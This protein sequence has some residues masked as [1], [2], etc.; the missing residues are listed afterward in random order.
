MSKRVAGKVALITGGARGQGRAHAM[1]LA[2]EGA[3]VVVVDRCDDLDTVPY[4]LA[5]PSDLDETVALV[6]RSGG[7]AMPVRADVRDRDAM[8]AAVEVAVSEFGG[9]DIVVANAGISNPSP[10]W[11]ITEAMWDEMI[12]VNLTGTWITV[13]AALPTLRGQGRGGS[14]VL[15]SSVAGLTSFPN[16][17]HYTAAKHGV[18]GLMR[19]LA[20]DLAPYSIR[21][22]SVHP[23]NVAT[24]M[25]HNQAV[26]DL[27]TGGARG[28]TI[29]DVEPIMR[30]GNALPVS[31]L[32]P[33]DVSNLVLWLA[34][35]ESRY[36]TGMA[37]AIDA[38]FMFP[39]KA[40]HL[41][42]EV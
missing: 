1:R 5:T 3:D 31:W 6:G 7:R 32:E 9:L 11:E 25:I 23:G 24:P 29:A 19:G 17:A 30:S 21:V 22:N 36:V 16:T 20:V 41:S 37:H 15:I 4:G 12:G 35:D 33:D 28:S 34:S 26:I 14:V 10:A 39:T 2:S 27:F 18:T 38:G 8:A 13:A 40:P 42:S